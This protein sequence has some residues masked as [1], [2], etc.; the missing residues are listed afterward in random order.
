VYVVPSDETDRALDTDG[1]IVASTANWEN[2]LKGQTGGHGLR[3]DTYQGTVD[4]SFFRMSETEAQVSA[5]GPNVRDEIERE[6]KAAGLTQPD[7][8]YAVYYDGIS[9][10]A[11]GGGAWPPSLPG[12]VGALY[13][14]STFWNTV[15]EPCYVPASSLAGLQLMDLA[16]VHE[17]VHTLGFV[18]SCSPH[19]TAAGHV[20]DSPTDLMYAGTQDWHPSVLDSGRDDYFNANI[21]GCA[22]LSNSRYLEGNE[23]VKLTVSIAS[24]GGQGTTTSDPAGI[25]CPPTCVAGFDRSSTVTLT[26]H[27][28]A[29]SRFTGWSGACADSAPTC[30]VTMDAAKSIS[31]V[32]AAVDQSAT[33]QTATPRAR[34]ILRATVVGS[35]VVKAG[36][37][38]GFT[39]RWQNTGAVSATSLVVC[40]RL[41]GQMLIVAARGAAA[42]ARQ[43]CWHRSSV[44]PNARLS[45]SF[46]TRVHR[47]PATTSATIVTTASATNAA[48]VRAR[49][50][51]R[52]RR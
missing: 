23:P 14:P 17:L 20:S 51:V 32:F 27:P 8:L 10:T 22:D 11:C 49:V 45:F 15:G 39:I 33:P 4:V 26:A 42:S 31:A 19:F 52:L 41:P 5:K 16:I 38:V 48:P 35:H 40:A 6:L 18:Q 36:H 50:S 24:T 44:A 9:T 29:G 13:L 12:I 43:A 37:R 7:K 46:I 47:R 30:R 1:T 21:P 2:W 3:L 28:T 25:D 34:M